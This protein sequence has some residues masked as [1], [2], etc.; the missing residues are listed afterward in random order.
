DPLAS[1]SN[2][3]SPEVVGQE[4]YE[5]ARGV[6]VVLQKYKDLQDIIAILGMD[7][8]SDEDKLTVHRARKIQRFL[9]QPFHVAE[10]FTGVAGEYCTIP[11]TVSGFK[12]I[13]EGKHDDRPEN[14]FYM[15]GTM[16]TVIAGSKQ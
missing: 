10:V 1:V 15:K 12:E 11:E 16:E 14:D 13:L 3:L 5:V 7:E 9:S 6:Q 8:L 2:A 4:H